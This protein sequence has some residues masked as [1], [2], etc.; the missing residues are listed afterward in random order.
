MH[1][2]GY[3]DDGE[4][5]PVPPVLSD[6][7][8]ERMHL[9]GRFLDNNAG[10]NEWHDCPSILLCGF[11]VPGYEVKNIELK[12]IEMEEP[13]EGIEDIHTEY[14]KDISFNNVRTVERTNK[15]M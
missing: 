14:T 10:K 15:Y 12:D 13:A 8:F 9:L 2:V 7:R 6:C 5:S 4:G 11:D 1:S 3:N